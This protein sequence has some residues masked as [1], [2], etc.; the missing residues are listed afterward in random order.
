MS[1][2]LLKVKLIPTCDNCSEVF[3]DGYYSCNINNH[4]LES[5]IKSKQKI[6]FK[7]SISNY[8]S[9]VLNI[10]QDILEKARL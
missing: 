3:E 1:K 6:I 10:T 7:K 4:I 2:K 8:T 9:C 5:L